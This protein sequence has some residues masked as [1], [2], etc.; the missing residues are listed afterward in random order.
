MIECRLKNI[1]NNITTVIEYEDK[2]AH[3]L[4]TIFDM[5][6][7]SNVMAQIEIFGLWDYRTEKKEKNK[8]GLILYVSKIIVLR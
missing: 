3:Y 2:D 7:Q 6:K 4:K 8:I 5:P 1:K